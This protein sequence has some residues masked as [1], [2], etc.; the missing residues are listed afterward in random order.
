MDEQR[1][2]KNEAQIRYVRIRNLVQRVI[3]GP[4]H[5]LITA[6]EILGEDEWL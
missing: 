3:V 1:W 6:S 5:N 2:V 4:D